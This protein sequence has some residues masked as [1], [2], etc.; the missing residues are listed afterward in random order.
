MTST[1]N[2]EPKGSEHSSTDETE[3]E[4]NAHQ[5]IRIGLALLVED[6][7]HWHSREAI[8]AFLQAELEHAFE[9][10]A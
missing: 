4:I 1:E 3:N 9:E 10:A 7:E 8:A 2:R 5:H 6:R